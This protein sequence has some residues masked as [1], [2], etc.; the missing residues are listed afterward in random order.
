MRARRLAVAAFGGLAMIV[1]VAA[2]S[3]A[4]SITRA[5]ALADPSPNELAAGAT[6]TLTG[7]NWQLQPLAL[8]YFVGA[9]DLGGVAVT[10]NGQGSFGVRLTV[11]GTPGN[12]LVRAVQDGVDPVSKPFAVLNLDGSRPSTNGGDTMTNGTTSGRLVTGGA[13]RIVGTVPVPAGQGAPAD[14]APASGIGG[15][16]QNAVGVAQAPDPVVVVVPAVEAAAVAPETQVVPTADA[17]DA[18]APVAPESAWATPSG[19]VP[20]LEKTLRTPSGRNFAAIGG[21]LAVGLIPLFGAFTALEFRRRRSL[22]T[23]GVSHE[24]NR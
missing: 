15:S 24:E 11:P 12:Y 3:W 13:P 20:G 6:M 22:A 7:T 17:G 23:N 8:H 9:T 16:P 19:A 10:P 21:W 5:P 14:T 18:L 2:V 1:G 4:C